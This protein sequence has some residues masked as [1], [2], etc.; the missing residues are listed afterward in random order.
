[1]L[2]IV[3]INKCVIILNS[4]INK[5]YSNFP[6]IVNTSLFRYKSISIFI[7]TFKSTHLQLNHVKQLANITICF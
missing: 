2:F 3:I 4:K 1:M 6:Y 5:K 7:L